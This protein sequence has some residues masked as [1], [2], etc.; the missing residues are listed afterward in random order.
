MTEL[1]LEQS[2]RRKG[3]GQTSLQKESQARFWGREK[4]G[5]DF[6]KDSTSSV[7]AL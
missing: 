7:D 3:G 5:V 1:T 4:A 2:K 6:G